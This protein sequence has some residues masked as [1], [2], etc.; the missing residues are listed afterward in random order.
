M[1]D[2][3]VQ[4]LQ[5]VSRRKSRGSLSSR[6]AAPRNDAPPIVEQQGQ[7][8]ENLP[9]SRPERKSIASEPIREETDVTS[10]NVKPRKRV[11][12]KRAAR[13]AASETID[14]SS[15]TCL[16][17]GDFHRTGY[18]PLKL[19]SIE[20]CQLCGIA[21]MAGKRACPMLINAGGGKPLTADSLKK[22]VEMARESVRKETANEDPKKKNPAKRQRREE[23]PQRKAERKGKRKEK[24]KGKREEKRDGPLSEQEA[25]VLV[26]QRKAAMSNRT[27]APPNGSLQ[28]SQSQAGPV[29]RSHQN[30]PGDTSGG[31]DPPRNANQN[32]GYDTFSYQPGSAV[33]YRSL[34]GQMHAEL[35]K[36]PAVS[37]YWTPAYD[38]LGSHSYG[39]PKRATPSS[40]AAQY[41]SPIPQS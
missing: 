13:L 33:G 20:K 36:D 34:D 14:A 10:D 22:A 26:A 41:T 21:H 3:D 32:Q 39:Y 8:L 40:T 25:A 37:R 6:K 23:D 24:L 12:V 28:I 9:L 11:D 19:A 16:V 29:N 4:E 30:L 18:C 38:I 1:Q 2:I 15:D 27:V 7:R 5:S 17:C 31:V 35:D